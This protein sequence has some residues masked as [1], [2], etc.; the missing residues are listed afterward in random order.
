MDTPY[1]K[2]KVDY[3][4]NPCPNIETDEKQMFKLTSI[5]KDIYVL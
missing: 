1:G 3:N 2:K 4:T 5:N